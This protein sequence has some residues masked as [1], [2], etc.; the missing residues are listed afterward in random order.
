MQVCHRKCIHEIFFFSTV[1]F[2]YINHFCFWVII[3]FIGDFVFKCSSY[4]KIVKLQ[5]PSI[6]N[7]QKKFT[8]SLSCKQATYYLFSVCLHGILLTTPTFLGYSYLFNW[9]DLKMK[10]YLIETIAKKIVTAWNYFYQAKRISFGLL[11][12]LHQCF[13]TAE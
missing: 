11:S 2:Q 5:F 3:Q 7:V 4:I 10:I 8:L 12:H 13:F 1:T 9:Y 6:Y